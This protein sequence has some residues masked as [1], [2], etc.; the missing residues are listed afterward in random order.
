MIEIV[1]ARHKEDW[2]RQRQLHFAEEARDAWAFANNSRD[3]DPVALCVKT[4]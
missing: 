2:P 4:S 3:D 1:V